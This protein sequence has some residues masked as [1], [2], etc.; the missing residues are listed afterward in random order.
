MKLVCDIWNPNAATTTRR[1]KAFLVLLTF[2]RIC[3]LSAVLDSHGT[4]IVYKTVHDIQRL[5][6]LIIAGLLV[7][8]KTAKDVAALEEMLKVKSVE[9]EEKK[10]QAEAI[11]EKVGQ[12]KAKVEAETARANVEQQKCEKIEAEVTA[13]QVCDMIL[14]G[15][16]SL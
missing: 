13:Q 8:N 3:C 10:E 7:L 15:T 14:H 6:F 11:A 1:Q 2:T 9:V 16:H 12:E 5:K 4:L